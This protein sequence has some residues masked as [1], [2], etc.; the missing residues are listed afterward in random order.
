LLREKCIALVKGLPKCCRKQLVQGPEVVDA[1]LASM[2]ADDVALCSA[3]A[4]ALRKT[5]GVVIA[6]QD[7]DVAGLTEFYRANIRVVDERGKLLAQGR[8]MAALV[9]KG[10]AS[11]QI[12]PHSIRL[13]I[14]ALASCPIFG[15][16]RP[17]A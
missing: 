16:P 13:K 1:A 4:T 12:L 8:D 6:D 17:L 14:G 3:L 7:W 15:A 2:Q 10:L 9:P 11:L 5:R